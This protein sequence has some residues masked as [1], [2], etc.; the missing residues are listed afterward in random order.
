LFAQGISRRCY[1]TIKS[2]QAL[3]IARIVAPYGGTLSLIWRALRK[4]SRWLYTLQIS[5]VKVHL[6]NTSNPSFCNTNFNVRV[7]VRVQSG[8]ESQP[9][10]HDLDGRGS[11]SPSPRLS[12]P[13]LP[14]LFSPR[15]HLNELALCCGCCLKACCM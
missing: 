4:T 6:H 3:W 14:L 15:P 10:M 8:S 12:H 11:S 9:L 1:S 5:K 13:R 7:R 2:N